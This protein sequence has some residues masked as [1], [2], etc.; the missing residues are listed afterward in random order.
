MA[1]DTSNSD[2]SGNTVSTFVSSLVLNIII[3][4]AVT[5]AFCILRP[6][7]KRVYAPRTYAVEKDRCTSTGVLQ[8][9]CTKHCATIAWCSQD[10]MRRIERRQ[11]LS[12][13]GFALP[14][15]P[16]SAAKKAHNLFSP[17]TPLLSA[18]Q[19]H[20]SAAKL[21]YG[22][23]WMQWP[24]CSQY[25]W[26]QL[27][28]FINSRSSI[29]LCIGSAP[30]QSASGPLAWISAALSVSD[31]KVIERVGLDSYM[32]LRSIRAMFF[33]FSVL[34]FLSVVTILPVNITA[35]GTATGLAV[36]SIGNVPPRAQSC[37]FHIVFFGVY[38]PVLRAWWLMRPEHTST[39]GASTILVSTLPET[40]LESDARIKQTFNMFP[41][42]VR[43]VF[44]NRN[45]ET[46]SKAVEKRDKYANKLEGLLTKYAVQCEKA[47]KLVEKKGG[48]YKEPKRPMMRE[49]S[50][51]FKGPKIDAI[52]FYSTQIA[53]LNLTIADLQKDASQFKKQSS[54]IAA[55]MAAQSVLDYKP[56][57]MDNVSFDVNPDDIIWS[58]LNMNPY[59]RQMRAYMSFG[60]T[61]GLTITWMILTAFVTSLV[62]MDNLRKYE[63]FKNIPDS[64]WLSLF[65]GFVPSI[66]IAVLMSLLPRILRLLLKLEGTRTMSEINLRLLHRFYF[67]QVWNVY[68][69]T[70]FANGILA[71]V[72]KVAGD[73]A[74][75]CQGDLRT[76]VPKTATAIVTY[77]LLLAFSGA[78]KEL[79]QGVSL[80]LRYVL[81]MILAKTPRSISDAEKAVRFLYVY[82]DANWITGG[83]SFP[84]FIKQLLVGVYISEVYMVLMMVAKLKDGGAEAIVRIVFAALILAGTI[85]AH[86]YINNAYMPILTYLPIPPASLNTLDSKKP[87]TAESRRR[88]HLYAIFG[89]LIPISLIDY[90]IRKV[91]SLIPSPITDALSPSPHRVSDEEISTEHK[92]PVEKPATASGSDKAWIDQERPIHDA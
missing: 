53:E 63:P 74:I 85:V 61:I 26:L 9:N 43:Q 67:F 56:F 57:S 38:T 92:P 52:N 44:V 27:L 29:Y 82:N 6:H 23:F 17:P 40:M 30:Q 14:C 68:F 64:K 8:R 54:C 73:P 36:L 71:V 78:A 79:L 46:L 13:L 62:S 75:Y 58:N 50:V 25:T 90:I 42:G 49:S 1:D 39:V 4:V 12:H 60:I 11:D 37:G 21:V 84:K 72:E 2:N 35:G 18:R 59:D 7:F 77:V 66:V 15:L 45:V 81:P 86:M 70:I 5:A 16:N 28:P 19:Q 76:E 89:T 51:P 80:A 55:H 3:G 48:E 47:Q 24:H 22:Y 83:L 20:G 10:A 31:D 88:R 41:G 33:M 87:A 91:P 65:Q 32:F 69:V 34:S